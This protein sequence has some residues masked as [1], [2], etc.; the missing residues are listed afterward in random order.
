MI[1]RR[2]VPPHKPSTMV[3]TWSGMKGEKL[4]SQSSGSTQQSHR[5]KR[6]NHGGS[7]QMGR[8]PHV[9]SIEPQSPFRKA[10]GG[11]AILFLSRDDKN[12]SSSMKGTNHDT[13][14]ISY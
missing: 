13:R 10:S 1:S 6:Y 11:S 9:C 2:F 5:M 12:A 4:V 3:C 14:T 8:H 7:T